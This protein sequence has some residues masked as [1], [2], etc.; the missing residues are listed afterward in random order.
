MNLISVDLIQWFL[1][2]NLDTAREEYSDD[3]I[4]KCCCYN[5]YTISKIELE[6]YFLMIDLFAGNLIFIGTKINSHD[7]RHTYKKK[8]YLNSNLSVAEGVKYVIV[9]K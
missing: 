4:T 8:D 5:N 1:T 3:E 2:N 9:H 7:V 6:K